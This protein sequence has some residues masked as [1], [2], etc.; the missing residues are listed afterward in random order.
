MSTHNL[1][2][3]G[4]NKQNYAL[5]IT[6]YPPYLVHWHDS[7]WSIPMIFQLISAHAGP[8]IAVSVSPDGKVLVSF[9]HL[10]QKIKFWQVIVSV[11]FINHMYM[12]RV[13]MFWS[14]SVLLYKIPVLKWSCHNIN[15]SI[16][17]LSFVNFLNPRHSCPFCPYYA[18]W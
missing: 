18:A 2:F 7:N 17:K 11:N 1:C 15:S 13:R 8:V 6:K 5:I 9:S 10:E 3:Y 12:C 14:T 4:K 16:Y